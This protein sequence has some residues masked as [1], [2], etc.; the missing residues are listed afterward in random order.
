MQYICMNI[1]YVPVLFLNNIWLVIFSLPQIIY[2]IL[3]LMI[4]DNENNF[5]QLFWW[6]EHIFQLKI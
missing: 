3:C 4:S 6:W 2:L 5:L 1:E